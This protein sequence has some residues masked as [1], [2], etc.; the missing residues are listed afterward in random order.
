MFNLA[1]KVEVS[2]NVL[3]LRYYRFLLQFINSYAEHMDIADCIEFKDG[4]SATESIFYLVA[5]SDIDEY[6][7]PSIY[8][9]CFSCTGFYWI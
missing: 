7:Y 3:L 5:T 1:I 2:K 8:Y 6:G 9:I 4:I